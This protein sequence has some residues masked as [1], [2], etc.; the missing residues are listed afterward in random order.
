MKIQA[1]TD[2]ILKDP[3][4]IRKILEAADW[5][6]SAEEFYGTSDALAMEKAIKDAESD[7][8]KFYI[9]RGQLVSLKP[10]KI[11]AKL[12]EL[13][14]LYDNLCLLSDSLAKKYRSAYEKF[15]NILTPFLQELA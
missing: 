9:S 12:T 3:K 6:I 15:K 11:Q 4:N 13:E 5:D 10:D 14:E 2:A 8:K 1:I 7:F